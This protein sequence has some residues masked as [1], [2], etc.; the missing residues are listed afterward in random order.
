MLAI[1]ISYVLRVRPV[2]PLS[3]V[4]S[5]CMCYLENIPA[6]VSAIHSIIVNTFNFMSWVERL[7][8]S[9]KTRSFIKKLTR[10]NI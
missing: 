10:N 5:L 2:P 7:Y 1:M 3:N 9:F 8:N 6:I 4:S